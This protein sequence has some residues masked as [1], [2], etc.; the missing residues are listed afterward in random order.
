LFVAWKVFVGGS[1]G[2]VNWQ[3]LLI[4]IASFTVLIFDAPAPLVLLIAGIV[5]MFIF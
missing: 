2:S 3:T 4:A 1:G 5:G